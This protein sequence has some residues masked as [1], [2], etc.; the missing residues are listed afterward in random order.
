MAK[1]SNTAAE[2]VLNIAMDYVREAIR[3]WSVEDS[4][5]ENLKEEF[6]DDFSRIF[7]QDK[8][9]YINWADV[10]KRLFTSVGSAAALIAES[11]VL[12]VKGPVG[13]L[14]WSELELAAKLVEI[15]ICPRPRPNERK[16]CRVARFLKDPDLEKRLKEFVLQTYARYEQ[17]Q[18]EPGPDPA[19]AKQ[20]PGKL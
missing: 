13:M 7:D 2:V 19:A 8:D 6:R 17:S 10:I 4:D 11:E 15:S 3:P 1:T 5:L 18:S 20:T 14:G 16:A 12:G 9:A